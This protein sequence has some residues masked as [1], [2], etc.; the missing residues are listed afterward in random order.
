MIELIE[1]FI[2]NA[3]VKKIE[4]LIVYN[5]KIC[6]LNGK[7]YEID[8]E[9]LNCLENIILTWKN[10]Y[11][12]SNK[13]DPEEFLIRIKTNTSLQKIHGKGIFPDNYGELLKLLGDLK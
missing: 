12:N 6:Y 13:I 4:A 3:G 11:G 8:N 10:E 2:Q 9:F 7:K 1:I 5:K